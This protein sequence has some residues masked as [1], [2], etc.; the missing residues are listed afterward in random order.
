LLEGAIAS[1]AAHRDVWPINVA[2]QSA[3]ALLSNL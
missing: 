1:A 2:A 3:E